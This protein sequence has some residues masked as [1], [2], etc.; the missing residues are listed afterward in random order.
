M[1]EPRYLIC[2]DLDRTIIPNGIAAESPQARAML[3]RLARREDVLLAYV[4]GRNKAL[5]KDAIGEY[6]LPVPDYAAGD[7]GSI[8]YDCR[9]EWESLPEW[10]AEIAADWPEGSRSLLEDSMQGFSRLERQ[11]SEK[12]NDFK[13]SYYAPPEF[14]E[15]GS[16]SE[17]RCRMAALVPA[18]EC[19]WSIDEAKGTG[20]LD[21]LP[22]RATKHH[23]VRFLMRL[24]GMEGG[25]T[26]FAGD[27]GND[28]P[29][30]TSGLQAILVANAR[31]E[32]KS[33]ALDAVRAKGCPD[34]LFIARGDFHGMNGNYA[35][36]VIE[37][38]C[39]F[40]PEL[41]AEL[42]PA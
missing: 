39:H 40:L 38:V 17:V 8:I 32:I 23:A 31:E 22:Q 33:L 2:S 18:T 28:L 16:L 14:G 1:T 10:Q 29:A 35:A 5:L 25:Q 4:T 42:L 24:C 7:V 37:G 19:V 13:L 34:R 20:L 12:Q 6:G 11:E 27:S 36:G 21:L 15:D 30:L 9:S 3:R 41:A 26:V